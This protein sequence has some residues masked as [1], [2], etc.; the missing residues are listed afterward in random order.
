MSRTIRGVVVATCLAAC[1]PSYAK[2][3]VDEIQTVAVTIDEPEQRFCAYWPV[4]MRA[5]VTYKDGGQARSSTPAESQRGMLRATEF[6]W[7]TSQGTVTPQA[8]LALAGDPLAWFDEPIEVKAEVVAR[9]EMVGEA[10][11][12]PRFD[13]GGHVDLRGAPG[14][15]GGEAEA[16]GNGAPGPVVEV[17]LAYV[18][19][20]RSGRL[21][22]VRVTRDGG[23][24]EHFLIG[25]QQGLAPF[26][27]DVRGGDG[28]RG[29]QGVAGLD[30]L[31]GIAGVDGPND[32]A[33]ADGGRGT[34]GTDGEPG[35]PGAPGFDGGDGGNGGRVT[36]RFDARFP[37]LANLVE[38]N[39]LGGA[40]GEAG[41]GGDGGRGGAAG[42]AGKAGVVCANEGPVGGVAG[43]QGMDGNP[44]PA[45]APGFE[46]APG[47]VERTPGDVAALFA[48]EV[49]RG[50]PVVIDGGGS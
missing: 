44:G 8:V 45:G 24:P 27:L 47:S 40:A 49:A 20:K 16:G 26:V 15:R 30:G 32:R 29:G 42:A 14:A 19:T 10:V 9:P 21:V 22:L 36:L 18:D 11:V 3:K 39:V 35:G 12:Q 25:A 4:A 50:L 17:A 5:V 46:G 33:C 28:G 48:D 6:A 38:V 37:E 41:K 13:C 2:L 7:S 31:P 43:T 1:G 23:A 34:D